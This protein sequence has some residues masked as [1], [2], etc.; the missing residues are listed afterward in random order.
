MILFSHR[1]KPFLRTSVCKA[2][3]S[4]PI[5][6][7]DHATDTRPR[8][9]SHRD[10]GDWGVDASVWWL[11]RST[12]WGW[13]PPCSLHREWGSI[14][15]G[16]RSYAGLEAPRIEQSIEAGRH[17]AGC[18]EVRTPAARTLGSVHRPGLARDP[19]WCRVHVLRFHRAPDSYTSGLRYTHKPLLFQATYAIPPLFIP[20]PRSF[21]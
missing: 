1:L 7:R 3:T 21:F 16:R 12:R 11:Q 19:R 17:G 20:W 8:L 2:G 4:R 6:K 18:E 13:H 10:V 9:D 14:S 15:E 5:A